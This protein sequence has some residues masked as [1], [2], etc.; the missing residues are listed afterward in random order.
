[1]HC[2]CC[3][4]L[5]AHTH[6][7]TVTFY[8]GTYP[9]VRPPSQSLHASFHFS[10]TDGV[11]LVADIE[12]ITSYLALTLNNGTLEATLSS[13]EQVQS[14]LSISL[15]NMDNTQTPQRCLE[16]T[17][18][19]DRVVLSLDGDSESVRTMLSSRLNFSGQVYLAGPPDRTSPLLLSTGNYIGCMTNITINLQPIVFYGDTQA[20]YSSG[21]CIPPRRAP[22]RHSSIDYHQYPW[23][24]IS[25]QVR[26]VAVDEGDNVTITDLNLGVWI[27]EDLISSETGYW[28]RSD[29]ESK[30]VFDVVS[31]PQFGFFTRGLSNARVSTLRFSD[32]LSD[33]SATRVSIETSCVTPPTQR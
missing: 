29:V 20:G 28:F 21:C 7:H 10:T 9:V 18:S 11:L 19:G 24:N 30:V 31:E 1:M 33:D 15:P 6:T 25:I 32:L 26:A 4:V 27:P 13:N 5:Y 22:L 16:L 8:G 2:C 17:V 3:T 14:L 23:N 12:H